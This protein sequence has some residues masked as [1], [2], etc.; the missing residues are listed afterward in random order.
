MN[1]PVSSSKVQEVYQ[2][3]MSTQQQRLTSLLRSAAL[4]KRNWRERERST[5]RMLVDQTRERGLRMPRMRKVM[6]DGFQWI[7]FKGKSTEN[8]GFY[9]QIR[10]SCRFPLIQFLE[11]WVGLGGLSGKGTKI[12]RLQHLVGAHRESSK[13]ITVPTR[14]ID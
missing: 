1:P 14:A 2:R 7:G 10:V 13:R 6:Q 11:G 9:L 5:L 4:W 3:L 8:H 12:H